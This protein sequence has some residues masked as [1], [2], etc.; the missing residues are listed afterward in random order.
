M[1]RRSGFNSA[2]GLLEREVLT[3]KQATLSTVSMASI[4]ALFALARNPPTL[5]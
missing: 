3:V 5:H 1:R 4:L 2:E